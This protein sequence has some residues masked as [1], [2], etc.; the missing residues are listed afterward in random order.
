MSNI[1]W[2]F[3]AEREGNRL[4][5]YVPNVDGSKSGVTIASGFDLGA[6]NENDIKD[7]PDSIQK[8]LKPFLGLKG[9]PA[10]EL[11]KKLVVT[12][13]EAKVI[14]DF[15]KRE[16]TLN[17]S[18]KWREKTGQEFA[19]LPKHKATVVASVAFQYGDLASKTPNFW[20]QTTTGDWD[21]ALRN[22][23]NFGDDYKTRRNM[24]GT[25][26]EQGM[27][28]EEATTT[29]PGQQPPMGFMETQREALEASR[30]VEG[31]SGTIPEPEVKKKS[32]IEQEPELPILEERVEAKPEIEQQ[33]ELPIIEERQQ[34]SLLPDEEE[35]LSIIETRQESKQKPEPEPDLPILEQR[36]LDEP[37]IDAPDDFDLIERQNQLEVAQNAPESAEVPETFKKPKPKLPRAAKPVTAPERMRAE[38]AFEAEKKTLSFDI[39]KRVIDQ[40][41]AMSYVFSGKEEFKPD[42]DFRL[43]EELARELTEGLPEDYHDGIIENSFSEAQAR[44]QREEALKQFSFDKEIGELGWKGVAL[45][46]G[47]AI[48]DPFAIA[49]SIG[50]EGV[51]AP[52]IWGN[53]LSR[54]G[55]VFR[56]SS[57]AATTNAAIEAYLVSQNDFKDP[58]DILY[59]MSAGLVI[60]GGVGALGRTDTSD[61][62]VGALGRMANHVDN[63][64]KIET[65]NAIKKNVLDGDPNDELS[66][67]AAVNPDS[68]PVQ[69]RDATS[70]L[71]EFLDQA[72]EPVQAGY[73]KLGPVPLRF[74]MAGYLLNSPNRI[75]NYLGRILPEDPLGFRKDKT[76]TVEASADILKTN[77]MKASF[78]KFYQVYDGAYKEWAKEQGFGL[79]KRTFNVPRRQ[80]GELV[81]DAIENP[82]FPVSSAI[83]RAADRQAEIQRDLLRAAK[84]AGVEGFEEIP[85]NLSYFT[86]LWDDFKFRD[87]GTKYTDAVVVRL[88]T[89]S[90]MSGTEDLQEEAA[91]R[92]ANA[93][94]NKLNRSAAGMDTGASRLFNATDRDVMRQILIDEEFMNAE[95]AD[96]L[97][98]LFSQRPDGTPARAKR[99]LRFNMNEEMVATNRQ[100]QQEVFRVKDLQERDAEQVFT[101]YAASMS[102]RNALAT[103][104][105]KSERRFNQLLDR[106][107]A[108]AAARESNAGRARAEKDNLVAQTIFNMVINRRAPLAADPKGNFAR[109]ARLVQDYNFIRLMNQ[110]GFAQIAEL[111]NALAIGGVRGVL[112]AVPSIKSMLKRARNGEIEDSVL[113]DLEAADGI[114]SDRL[115]M[116]AMNRAD[117]IGVFSEGRG[118][119]I[120]K[121]LFAMQPLKRITADLS[122]MAPVT[123]ALERVAARCAVQTLTNMAF[124]NK[125]LSVARL[126][127]LGLDDEMAQKVFAQ[128]RKNAVTQKS[129]F[130]RN[131]TV[132]AINLAEWDDGPA[133]D[134]FTVAIARWTRRSIQQNDVGNLNLYMT[135]TM[136]Q[137]LTQFRT[138]MLVS[139]AKQFLH[140]IKANDFK[141]YSAM[142]YS[143]AFAGLAY[144]AQTQANSIGRED[145]EE[146]LKERL[147]VESV[148]KAS[149]QRSS[150][151]ALFPGLIDTG[152]A[153]F[154]DD[155]IF[156]YRSTG[157]DTQFITGNPTVQLI[158]KGIGS[159]QAVSRSILNPDL[160]FSQGQQRA[161]NTIIPYNNALGI[162]N[163]L[164]KLVEMRP[165]TTKVE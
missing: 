39:A 165:E 131:K 63:A 62:M 40:D 135:S 51:A 84:E 101:S 93:M 144:M 105:I 15:A 112:Q 109:S 129:T 71:D 53:K 41:W 29:P 124:T 73:T 11:A 57:T 139:H 132:K 33:K 43:T 67:G 117:T 75:A 47:A 37:Q 140:N 27:K 143:S 45:R 55:R 65:V 54:L 151:A 150:W 116:Q 70:D 82:E 24:E 110:V 86:H 95:E 25:Y 122:G 125:G 58:Y 113:R 138:F 68:L 74:D 88:L 108:E 127:G 1:D 64:Q 120:D 96:S 100:G 153:F 22:L 155:P 104:G 17:L 35:P 79:F 160:Q 137:I 14:N 111:G 12:S 72:G 148:A 164:N 49:V 76:Q 87:A 161:L 36:V 130:F 94:F 10:E 30:L 13:N 50:T 5:G 145:R 163:A 59:S 38:K 44:F 134:A 23:R 89:N 83:R 92:I 126:K 77:S 7:L 159:A 106:N 34:P 157:L 6:R 162:K 32:K 147:S 128:I 8:K 97:M 66:I 80:F 119:L 102:G 146:F 154:M 107:L 114:G 18:R 16:A 118:D 78:A 98:A 21:G 149:F 81:A 19:E 48:A 121:A 9:Q 158:S 69:I 133:R 31:A 42:P 20:R 141:G 52:A 28:M 99:R 2:D 60:G 85:E 90:L 142:I 123:L 3:I 103:V 46:M 91:E 156:A 56:G 26:L 61:P 136:G 4:I 115:T 152:A